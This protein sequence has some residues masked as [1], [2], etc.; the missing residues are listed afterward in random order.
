MEELNQD[1]V[2]FKQAKKRSR[3]L[4]RLKLRNHSGLF[5]CARV[6]SGAPAAAQ[7]DPS[8]ACRS[9]LERG[10]DYLPKMKKQIFDSARLR[11]VSKFPLR[12]KG[13]GSERA[14]YVQKAR[15]KC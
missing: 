11:P 9:Q 8:A 2:E 6:L 7:S 4:S 5:V 13:I 3:G 1:V 15:R 14:S 10:D 12:K